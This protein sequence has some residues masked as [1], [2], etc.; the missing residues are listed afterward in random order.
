MNSNLENDP[1]IMEKLEHIALWIKQERLRA[2]ISQI[3]LALNAGLSQNHIYSIESGQRIP[4]LGTFL[5]ICKALSLN[6]AK[7]FKPPD[8]ER[9]QD[10]DTILTILGKYL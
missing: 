9:Q 4:H 1:E 7:L 2:K 10:K 8:E 6:P 3:D 5:K